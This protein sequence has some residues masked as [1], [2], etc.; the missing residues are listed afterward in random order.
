MKAIALNQMLQAMI[1]GNTKEN[2]VHAWG[3]WLILV[4]GI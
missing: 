3:I 2:F 1:K 4:S